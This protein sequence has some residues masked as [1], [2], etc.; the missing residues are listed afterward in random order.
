MALSPLP[1]PGSPTPRLTPHVSL[2]TS[3][4]SLPYPSSILQQYHATTERQGRQRSPCASIS[5]GGPD[6]RTVYVGS[7]KGTRI[8]YFR[9]PVAGLPMAHW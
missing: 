7:L 8:P 4:F 3:H 1:S 6:L 5:F 9:S 2:L